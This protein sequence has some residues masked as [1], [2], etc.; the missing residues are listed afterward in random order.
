VNPDS[1]NVSVVLLIWITETQ[2]P[3][4]QIFRPKSWYSFC[5]ETLFSSIHL[6]VSFTPGI[7]YLSWEPHN[8]PFHSDKGHSLHNYNQIWNELFLMLCLSILLH[9]YCYASCVWSFAVFVLTLT[10]GLCCLSLVCP[11]LCWFWHPEIRTSS[12]NW[13]QLHR[14]WRWWQGPVSKTFFK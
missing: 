12:I 8:A 11:V 10:D 3:L 5:C 1:L 13:V 7:H 14:L 6:L 9:Y 2:F 4:Y